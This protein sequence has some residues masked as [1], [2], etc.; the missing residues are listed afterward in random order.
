MK[1][2]NILC[3]LFTIPQSP[4]CHWAQGLVSHCWAMAGFCAWSH[5]EA[6]TLSSEFSERRWRHSMRRVCVPDPQVTL[7][8]DH[9]SVTHLL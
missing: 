9:S 8:S 6:E 2:K 5:W 1:T 7:H 4:V 3:I